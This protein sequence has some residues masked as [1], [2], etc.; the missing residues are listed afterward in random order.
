ME[1]VGSNLRTERDKDQRSSTVI[2][3]EI[4]CQLSILLIIVQEFE[5]W[6][7]SLSQEKKGII[8]G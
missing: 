4:A 3:R 5:V 1:Q 6:E 2:Y 7:S 8:S